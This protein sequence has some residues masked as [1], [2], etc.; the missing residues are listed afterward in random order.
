MAKAIC[1]DCGSTDLM[2]ACFGTMEY[3]GEL[4]EENDFSVDLETDAGQM[5]CECSWRGCLTECQEAAK[6]AENPEKESIKYHPNQ[7]KLF[8]L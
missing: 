2:I 1:P 8:E 3:D 6:K 5:C 7:E 4:G